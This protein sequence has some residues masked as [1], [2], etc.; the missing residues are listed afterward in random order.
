MIISVSGEVNCLSCHRRLPHPTAYCRFCGQR[1]IPPDWQFPSDP[2]PDKKPRFNLIA[3][4]VVQELE[5][6]LCWQQGG[7]ER[8]LSHGQARVYLRRLNT[9]ALGGRRDWRLPT[10]AELTGLLTEQKTSKELYINRMFDSQWRVCWSSTPSLSGGAY[11]V[12]FYPGSVLAQSLT[13][14]AYIKAVA[15]KITESAGS[16]RP[17]AQLLEEARQVLFT[18]SGQR[19]IPRWPELHNLI[20]QGVLLSDLVFG[21]QQLYFIP[22]E[23]WLRGLIRLFQHLRVQ[24]VVEVGAGDGLVAGALAELGYPIIATD[25]KGPGEQSPYGVPVYRCSHQEALREFQPDLVFWCWPPLGSQAPQEIIRH[26]QVRYYL[27]I[28]DGGFATGSNTLV[29][30]FQGRYLPYLSGL[31]FTWLD[32]G[33]YRH[34]RNFL[35]MRRQ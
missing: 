22:T 30:D 9:Q 1:L 13:A 8:P 5:T 18:A 10:L 34:N 25:L 20:Q 7:S 32:A 33:S 12:L 23:E 4:G 26:P 28:G 11:G 6:G 15:G 35:F 31:G 14:P 16:G 19:R 21:T 29:Q 3:P 2:A 24:R 17:L 27:D